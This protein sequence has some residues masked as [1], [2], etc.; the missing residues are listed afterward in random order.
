MM[1][2]VV[3][4]PRLPLPGESLIGHEFRTFVG[5]KGGNQAIAAK[6]LG[7]GQ[8]AMIGRVGADR[9]GEKVLETLAADGVD[10]THVSRDPAIGTGVALPLVFDDGT[11]SIISIPQANL[12]LT[13]ADIS[14]A[15]PA[16]EGANLLL[17]QFEVSMEATLAAMRIAREAGVRV[18]LNAA[19][20]AAEPL[21]ALA[22]ATYLVVN[23][24]EAAALA[25]AAGGD[26]VREARVL[27]ARGPGAVIVTL[28]EA[29]AIVATQDGSEFVA[30]FSVPAADS[31]GAGDAFCGGFAVGITEG[32]RLAEAA[33]LGSAAGAVSVTRRGAVASLPVR[34][35]VEALLRR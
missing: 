14:T 20:V 26:H 35:E 29:G 6:R 34:D 11:N 15:R 23:E 18:V 25:P 1:D 21:E 16:I 30:P 19:P 33:R 7:A 13:S 27:L 28:G 31:V 10:C 3:R 17:V 5:G 32:M 8:V 4:V 2:L 24:V 9:F 22:L 12:A